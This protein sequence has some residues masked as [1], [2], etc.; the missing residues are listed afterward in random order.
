MK[1]ITRYTNNLIDR[2]TRLPDSRIGR[3]LSIIA[4]V[5]GLILLVGQTYA[6][7]DVQTALSNNITT[8]QQLR[9]T[10]TGIPTATWKVDI[11]HLGI[12]LNIPT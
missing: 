12:K 4:G 11:S 2:M 1:H 6:D 3:G 5:A 10:I 9:T 7:I 8:L